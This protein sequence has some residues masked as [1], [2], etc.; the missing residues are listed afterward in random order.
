M[1]LMTPE[2]ILLDFILAIPKPIQFETSA[3]FSLC[4][5]LLFFFFCGP[6]NNLDIG[7]GKLFF[8]LCV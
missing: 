4:F 6:L 8:P 2:G 7:E 5:E 1:A 3:I